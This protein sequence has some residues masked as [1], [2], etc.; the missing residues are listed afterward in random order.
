MRY[1][2]V[3]YHYYFARIVDGVEGLRDASLA[4]KIKLIIPGPAHLNITAG[5]VYKF[6]ENKTEAITLLEYLA[7]YEGSQ[8]LANKNYEHPLKELSK[9]RIVSKFGDLKP[10]NVT[11]KELGKFNNKAIK[12][13]RETGWD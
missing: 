4:E 7:S 3:G 9:N 12:I 8:G 13:M 1:W 11:I 10:D 6:A 2:V 5:G